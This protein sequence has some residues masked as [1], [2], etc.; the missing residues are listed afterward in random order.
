MGAGFRERFEYPW[1]LAFADAG[2]VTVA[3]LLQFFLAVDGGRS[4]DGP[5]R[6]M[7]EA[8]SRCP[9]ELTR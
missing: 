1:H 4:L 7:K 2:T 9:I 5:A 6:S 8:G 3:T